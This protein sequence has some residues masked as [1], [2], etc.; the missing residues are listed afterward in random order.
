[1]TVKDLHTKICE[2]GQREEIE[3]F[4]QCILKGGTWPILLWQQI[5][6][7]KIAFKVEETLKSC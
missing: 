1:M 6:A 3:A 2:K 7:M 5:Q 4:A